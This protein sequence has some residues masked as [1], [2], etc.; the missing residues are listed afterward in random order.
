MSKRS[1]LFLI[2]VFNILAC[3][4][5]VP[6]HPPVNGTSVVHNSTTISISWEAVPEQY[7]NGIIIGYNVS[8]VESDGYLDTECMYLNSSGALHLTIDG[9]EK[10]TEYNIT[11]SAKTSKGV[12][13]ESLVIHVQTAQD[14]E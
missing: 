11:V 13:D 10:Y 4:F 14:G 1:L 3:L 5:S 8:I 7:R 2:T 6:S 9:L 12:S